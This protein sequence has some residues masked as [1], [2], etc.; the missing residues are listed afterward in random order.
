VDR[1]NFQGGEGHSALFYALN[2]HSSSVETIKILLSFGADPNCQ[3]SNG[4]LFPINPAEFDVDG[5]ELDT[6]VNHEW[7]EE[8]YIYHEGQ[9]RQ[10]FVIRDRVGSDG[11]YEKPYFEGYDEY[12][13]Y[14]LLLAAGLN[15]HEVNEY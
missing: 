1:D 8:V 14:H 3:D 7:D 10:F 11:L 4:I 13:V 5:N 2:S 15:V 12:S 6:S 9:K